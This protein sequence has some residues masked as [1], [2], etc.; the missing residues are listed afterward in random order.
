MLKR[1]VNE[2]RCRITLTAEGPVLVKSGHAA[3]TGPDMTPVRTHRAGEYQVYLPGS[4]L[5]GV[6]RSHL[7]KICRTLRPGTV[8]NPFYK[9]GEAGRVQGDALVCPDYGEVSCGERFEMR[10][11]GEL[12]IGGSTWKRT[13]ERELETDTARVYRES[14]PVC[15]LFGSQWYIGR[16]SIGDAYLSSQECTENR[17]GVGIDRVSGGAAHGAKFELEAVSSG[18]RFTTDILVRNFECWQVG[19]LMTA[20][21]DLRDGLVRI[22]S[23]RSRGLG[24]VSAHI[25]EL[26][27]HTLAP[28][29]GRGAGEVW[30][31]GRFLAEA[32]GYGTFSDDS[33][34]VVA[35]PEETTRGI[36]RVTQ[37]SGEPLAELEAAAQAE[38]LR[39]LEAWREMAVWPADWHRG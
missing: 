4:S 25:D 2:L 39:R 14:C 24:A 13:Q 34:R 1:L 32:D 5:K 36:R 10:R 30:G 33:L 35:A 22:G 3:V 37:F 28:T 26:A 16:I 7:E 18:V 8:C 29:P 11:R 31:L 15:R 38:L 21:A 17:D 12:L 20:V 9:P 23:G 6:V 19:M 27:I